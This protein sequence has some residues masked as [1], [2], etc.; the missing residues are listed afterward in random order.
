MPAFSYPA[1]AKAVLPS[2]IDKNPAV[3]SFLYTQME[4]PARADEAIMEFFLVGKS[5]GYRFTDKDS[6]RKKYRY[7]AFTTH[8]AAVNWMI[9]EIR[10]YGARGWVLRS[11]EPVIIAIGQKSVNEYNQ[12]GKLGTHWPKVGWTI[13]EEGRRLARAA[14]GSE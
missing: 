13:F 9:G 3:A 12:T 4:R 6:R 1:W 8:E 2:W 7:R 5:V 11:K 14:E 10:R